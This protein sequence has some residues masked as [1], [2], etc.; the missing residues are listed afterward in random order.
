MSSVPRFV[1]A[2]CLFAI[3]TSSSVSAASPGWPKSL[4]IGT[5]SPGGV[6]YVYGEALAQILTEKLGI[7]VNPLP[8]Q[9]SVHNVR[10]EATRRIK[11]APDTQHIPIIALVDRPAATPHVKEIE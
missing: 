2:A 3:A 1:L 4:T 10:L 9:S 7:A 11:A 8:A 5:A 6:S